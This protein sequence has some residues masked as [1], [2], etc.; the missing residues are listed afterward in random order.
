MEVYKTTFYNTTYYNRMLIAKRMSK[1][2]LKKARCMRLNVGLP[3][4]FWVEA[5]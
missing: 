3:K 2:L 1:N 4:V 5:M